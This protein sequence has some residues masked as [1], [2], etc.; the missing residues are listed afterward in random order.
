MQILTHARAELARVWSTRLGRVSL[1]AL[2]TTPL[3]YGGLYLWGN[4]DPYAALDRVPAALVVADTGA[5][6][7]DGADVDYGRD[8]A[9]EL[10]EAGD[11]DWHELDAAQARAGVV[12][13][14][15]DFALVFPASFSADL[16]STDSTDPTRASIT[17]ITNDANSYLST[18]IAKQAAAAVR[19][20]LVAQVGQAATTELLESIGDIRDGIVD[21]ADGASDLASGAGDAADGADSLSDGLD[22]LDA[23]AA[24]L[25]TGTADVASG[26]DALATGAA[27]ARAAAK[28]LAAGTADV[29]DAASALSDGLDTLDDSASALPAAATALSAGASD[30]AT[31]VASAATGAATLAT[32]ASSLDDSVATLRSSVAT[33]MDGYG[34]DATTQAAILAG[35]DELQ[36]GADSLA[37]GTGS[38]A[39]GLTTASSGAATVA[40]GAATLADSAPALASGLHTAATGA[41]TLATGAATVSTGAASLHSATKTLATGAATL[42]TGAQDAAEGAT[43]LASGADDAASGAAELATGTA[44]LSSGAHR[45]STSLATAEQQIPDYSATDRSAIA[46]AV[47]DPASVEQDAITEAANYGAGLAPFFIALAGWIGIYALFLILRPLSRR[48]VTAGVG[49]LR[50]MLAGWLVPAALG[51][52]EMIALFGVVVFA[53]GL[54]VAHPVLLLLLMVLVAVGY[55]AI[56]LALNAAF[57]SVGQFL[58]LILMIVQLV[59]AGGTFPWQTLPGP[60]AAVHQALPMAHAVAAIRQ[61]MYGGTAQALAQELLPLLAWL[62]GGLAVTAIAAAKQRRSRSLREVRPAAIGG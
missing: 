53:L 11:F 9:E 20:E 14:D 57:G 39:E 22:T 8:A 43:S 41:A 2:M 58:G 12:A 15:Y 56:V 25:A 35:F 49:P 21:A 26:A 23:G 42:A 38:L 31:G 27:E 6:D 36:D 60:L 3:F 47:A 37:E 17:L 54:P 33:V 16:L 24:E 40:A 28:R 18:T 34:V 44:R 51:A 7:D 48:A 29:A 5:T 19:A 59:T 50:T 52:V 10:L 61:L 46:E 62:L 32:G 55:A 30:V 13:G 45:L 4:Q 1:V